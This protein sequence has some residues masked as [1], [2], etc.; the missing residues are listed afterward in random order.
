MVELQKVVNEVLSLIINNV[1]FN[2]SIDDLNKELNKLLEEYEEVQ[3]ELEK[4]IEHW[5]KN[6]RVVSFS[7]SYYE[8]SDS[9]SPSLDYGSNVETL[10]YDGIRVT[11]DT[12]I[13]G[14]LD[15]K[16]RWTLEKSNNPIIKR[17]KEIQAK[18]DEIRS[19]ITERYETVF[20]ELMENEYARALFS[21]L[22]DINNI[23]PLKPVLEKYINCEIEIPITS[24]MVH[25]FKP[26]SLEELV[27]KIKAEILYT[28]DPYDGC[29]GDIRN[30]KDYKKKFIEFLL[31]QRS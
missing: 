27:N 5:K 7:S 12:E 18:I 29:F 21:L 13:P 8:D 11:Y 4:Y 30:L 25:K 28:I 6:A 16:L 20:N 31:N 10:E 22:T 17:L 26:E 9:W 3:R 23:D 14:D 15:L 1:N 19:R 24:T 2:I